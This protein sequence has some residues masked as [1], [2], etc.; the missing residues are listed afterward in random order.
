MSLVISLSDTTIWIVS[1][2]TV[3]Y[4]SL[5][6]IYLF[7]E[8]RIK[9]TLFLFWRMPS[10]SSCII[11]MLSVFKLYFSQVSYKDT[12]NL[13][14]HLM[15]LLHLHFLLL[16]IVRK[17]KLLMTVKVLVA[18]LLEYLLDPRIRKLRKK[19]CDQ[20]NIILNEEY[21]FSGIF[22]DLRNWGKYYRWK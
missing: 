5:T 7:K 4:M 17:Y 6:L 8:I 12:L 15:F 18:H 1:I 19:N 3:L 2:L 20:T 10:K 14:L 16:L 21:I 13:F 9:I 22:E 11:M